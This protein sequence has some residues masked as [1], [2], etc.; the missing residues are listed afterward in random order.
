M[1]SGALFNVGRVFRSLPRGQKSVEEIPG[2]FITVSFFL[3]DSPFFYLMTTESSEKK[4]QGN[5]LQ[6]L[7]GEC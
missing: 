7:A 1:W 6:K 4:G 3:S 2:K 5:Y